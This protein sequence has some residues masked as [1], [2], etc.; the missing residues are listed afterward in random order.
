MYIEKTPGLAGPGASCNAT[1]PLGT[2][3]REGRNSPINRKA[4]SLGRP[5]KLAPSGTMDL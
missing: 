1:V 3:I 4:F 2:E 5:G